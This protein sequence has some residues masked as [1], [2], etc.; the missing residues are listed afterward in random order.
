MWTRWEYPGADYTTTLRN[1]LDHLESNIHQG[2]LL[3]RDVFH[4]STPLFLHSLAKIQHPGITNI[5]DY[6]ALGKSLFELL[7]I[8]AED[9][10]EFVDLMVTFVD[11][12]VDVSKDNGTESILN[13]VPQVRVLLKSQEKVVEAEK[14]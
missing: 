5:L 10:P 3:F 8:K 2:K 9:P 11:K 14:N 1:V 4:G 7:D 13:N 12:D 6:P